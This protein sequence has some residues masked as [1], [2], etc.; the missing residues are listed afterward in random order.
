VP[1]V[2]RIVTFS[3]GGRPIE[4]LN[5]NSSPG[6]VTA[7]FRER[8]TFQ[9][10][11]APSTVQYSRRARRYGGARATGE[12]HDNGSVAW[13]V[14]VRGSTLATA[15]AN[16]EAL[17]AVITDE[18]RGR[19][20]EWQPE[21][22]LSSFMEI[23]GPGTWTPAY[24]PVEFVQTNAMRVQLVFPTAP[25]VRWI[26]PTINDPFDLNSIA[27]YTFDAL[28]SAD[29][30]ITGGEVTP[31]GAAVTQ[32]RRVRYTA[33]GYDHLE[34]Q[35]TL[36]F[37]VGTTLSGFKVGLLMRATSASNYIEVSVDDDG[38]NSHLRVDV[39]VNGAR[40]TRSIT[41]LASRLTVSTSYWLRA[42]IS[43]SGVIGATTAITAEHFTAQPGQTTSPTNTASYTLN[44]ADG[45]LFTTAG[46][47]GFSWVP[48]QSSAR[49]DD[50]DFAPYVTWSG[51]TTVPRMFTPLD[52][53]PGTAPALADVSISAVSAT[54]APVFALIAWST[55]AL[56]PIAGNAPFNV[57]SSVGPSGLTGVV[58]GISDSTNWVSTTIPSSLSNNSLQKAAV[59][60]AETFTAAWILDPSAL[61]S[62]DFSA[63]EITLEFW[64]RMSIAST[65]VSPKIVA[66][67]RSVEGT[68]FGAERYTNE[69]GAAGEI[70]SAYAGWFQMYR[71]GTITV[72]ASRT[73]RR[74]MKFWITMTTGTGS[75]GTLTM[76]HIIVVPVRQ[77]CLSPTAKHLDSSYP[78]FI[79]STTATTKTIRSDLSGLVSS[80]TG[81]RMVDH[82]L[83]GSLIEPPPGAVDWIVRLGV[84]V[85]DDPI[86][87]AASD[88]A[89]QNSAFRVDLIPRSYMLRT[90]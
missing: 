16:V 30:T 79:A 60:G 25:L 53:V 84:Q 69:W 64:A 32:E 51:G 3:P 26:P 19:F 33:R 63:D 72:P 46:K 55:R 5:L 73:Y 58:G 44:V 82:G 66:S 27:D 1:D 74:T 50:F 37:A 41:N 52:N 18:A 23:A 39:V 47:V 90:S 36:R 80:A 38:T 13:T 31:T 88:P 2:L 11:P 57:I 59:S 9:F 77:R 56:T 20:V 28:T 4:V 54:A 15:V 29:L 68:S 7:Y 10:T 86:A 76:D 12:T 24:D 81:A 42:R 65:I 17:L 78:A 49:I 35:V 61:P 45:T 21:G 67:V 22:G 34:G 48:N 85:P 6:T 40:A 14:Y 71:L 43:L 75:T 89:N 62:D 83:G 87:Q 8:G 70:F